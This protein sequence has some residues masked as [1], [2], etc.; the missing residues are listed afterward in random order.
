[1]MKQEAS[2]EHGGIVADERGLGKTFTTL[3][4]VSI[5]SRRTTAPQHHPRPCRDTAT[6]SLGETYAPGCGLCEAQVPAKISAG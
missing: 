3:S 1:M 4:L 2:L 6:G 5:F